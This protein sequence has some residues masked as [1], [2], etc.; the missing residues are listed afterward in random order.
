MISI[1]DLREKNKTKLQR[2]NAPI[3]TKNEIKGLIFDKYLA[4]I[5]NIIPITDC[6]LATKET[7]A[8]HTLWCGAV[9]KTI[10]ENIKLYSMN[11]ISDF[12]KVVNWCI[13]NEIRIVNSS[14][15]SFYTKK[16][17]LALQ[18]YAE[19]GGIWVSSA[20]NN[21]NDDKLS[22]PA[23]SKFVV[24]VGA[25]N[26]SD[27]NDITLDI[28]ADS[29]WKVPQ[30]GSIDYSA[31]NGT[32]ATSPV[33]FTAASY[34][35][36]A[37]PTG[38]LWSFRKWEL[39]NSVNNLDD[40]SPELVGAKLENGE[41][42]F[43]FPDNLVDRLLPIEIELQIDSQIMKVNGA[44]KKLRVAPFLK[45]YSDEF[46]ATCTEIRPVFE[47]LGYTVSYDQATKTIKITK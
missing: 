30:T 8:V 46:A 16:N 7:R 5:H 24:S 38:N 9:A 44:D 3:K 23:S 40:I 28:V 43:V 21:G 33:I 17:D 15:S 14:I 36:D 31:F 22:F 13:K 47:E 45:K 18:K 34:Y 37:N 26:T 2:L 39:V 29:Y 6:E 25:T 27:N 12:E 11:Y 4:H 41:R 42:F 1:N 10:N 32:S 35:L 19:W 20:G